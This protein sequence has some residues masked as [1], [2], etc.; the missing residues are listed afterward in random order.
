MPAAKDPPDINWAL[1]ENRSPGRVLV[2][3]DA[4]AFGTVTNP[5]NVTG[6]TT[7]PSVGPTG[8]A[9][10]AQATQ[11]AGPD[12]TGLLLAPMVRTTDPVAGNP[13]IVARIAGILSAIVAGSG[14][15]GAPAAGV[16]TVQGIAGGTAVPITDNTTATLNNGAE[17]AVAGVAVQ[18]LAANASRKSALIQ[19]T[20]TANVRVG[21]T[22]VAAT[23]GFR[24][25]PD[26]ILTMQPPFDPTNAI[27]AIR[28]GGVD[29]IVF[30]LEVT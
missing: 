19:N 16:V 30:A 22:G 25:T 21:T 20:G 17:T 18:V 2:D 29:S 13:G 7:N 6:S 15:A 24:L 8:A 14:T 5:I 1:T 28:E 27:F 11:V 12:P 9:V 10:P 26:S 3:K 23:T 4:V